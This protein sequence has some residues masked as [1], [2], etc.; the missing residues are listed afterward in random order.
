MVNEATNIVLIGNAGDPVRYRCGDQQAIVKGSLLWLDPATGTGVLP[1][2]VSGAHTTDAPAAGIAAMDKVAG[3]GSTSISV[4][5]NVI[6]D[7]ST[8]SQPGVMF[9]GED[10]RISGANQIA[11]M[12]TSSISGGRV[13]GKLLEPVAAGTEAVVAVRV[14]L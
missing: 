4:L 13:L 3:D 7:L 6:A 8:G 5:T 1:L 12:D 10:V 14:N 2:Q 11:P 9:V